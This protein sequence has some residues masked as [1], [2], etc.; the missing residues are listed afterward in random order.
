M[1]RHAVWPAS[2]EGLF[3]TVPGG[4]PM[5][6]LVVHAVVILLPLSALALLT[7]VLV[8]RWR[9]RF[10]WLIVAGLGLGAAAAVAAKESGE[11]LAA[12]V[13]WPQQHSE[14]GDL[15][16]PVALLL[17]AVAVAWVLGQRRGRT[18]ALRLV[19]SGTAVVLAL[20]TTVLTVLVGHSG[21]A[22]VWG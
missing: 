19:L 21:A 13:G 6:P 10:D 7:I 8:R 1:H 4:L 18:G 9:G 17:F 3:D 22:A 11:Q 12:R 5:H 2:A 15:L 20:V 14:W 16:P